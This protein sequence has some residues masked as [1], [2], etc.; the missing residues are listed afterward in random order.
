MKLE[1]L[2][3]PDCPDLAPLLDR[4]RQVTDLPVITYEIDTDDEAAARG[5]SGSPTLLIDGVDPFATPELDTGVSCRIYRDEDGRMIPAPSAAQLRDAICSAGPAA[6]LSTWRTRALPL[7]PVERAVH[8]AILRT[9]AA[10]SQPPARDVLDQVTAGSGTTTSAVLQSLHDGDAIRLDP[11]GQIVVAYPFSATPTVH[12][13]RIGDRVD[14]YAMCAIDALG[15]AA[16]LGEDTEISSVDVTTGR[17]ITVTTTGGRT[18]WEPAGAVVFVGADAGGGASAD[19]CR[20]YLNFFTDTAA[21]EAWTTSHPQV[22]G[23]VLTQT[24]AQD[25]GSR[26]FQP[27]LAA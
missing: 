16:M 8:Q 11:V 13:V 20:D 10:T 19:C 4:L 14:V 1:V 25:L 26:L 2:H 7:D 22:P 27:L 15:M 6:A 9:F 17:Q 18:V 23:Q 12:R 24:E 5:M 21:A 3:V